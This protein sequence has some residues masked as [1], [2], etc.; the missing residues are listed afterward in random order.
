MATRVEDGAYAALLLVC[1]LRCRFEAVPCFLRR[2]FSAL[3]LAECMGRAPMA[4]GTLRVA[5]LS[6]LMVVAKKLRVA[7]VM[8]LPRMKVWPPTNADDW[9]IGAQSVT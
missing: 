5:R 8:R 3:L 9:A 4:L 2:R 1:M 6:S 7:N